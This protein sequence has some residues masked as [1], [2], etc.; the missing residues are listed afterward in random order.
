MLEDGGSDDGVGDAERAPL[1]LLL[2]DQ[3]SSPPADVSV[4][5]D[6]LEA[7]NKSAGAVILLYTINL[8]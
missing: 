4:Y 7:G 6:S 1:A 3:L 8:P 2:P 5:R